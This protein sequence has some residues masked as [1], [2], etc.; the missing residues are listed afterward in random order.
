MPRVF[1]RSVIVPG[2]QE[3][4]SDTTCSSGLVAMSEYVPGRSSTL[5]LALCQFPEATWTVVPGALTTRWRA[6]VSWLN[7]VD[8]PTLGLPTRAIVGSVDGPMERVAVALEWPSDPQ[9]GQLM[10]PPPRESAGL[11]GDR[12]LQAVGGQIT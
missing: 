6:P 1:S 10:R 2:A 3:I 4:V 7:S 12:R 8:L 9:R 11:S 5:S